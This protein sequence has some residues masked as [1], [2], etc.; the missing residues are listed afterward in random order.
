MMLVKPSPMLPEWALPRVCH[1]LEHAPSLLAALYGTRYGFLRHVMCLNAS[2]DGDPDWPALAR[3]IGEDDTDPQVSGRVAMRL[4]SMPLKTLIED[5]GPL[6]RI[7]PLIASILRKTTEYL[8]A[9]TYRELAALEGLPG[10][11]PRIRALMK[12]PPLT[13]RR[14]EIF[15]EVDVAFAHPAII[16]RL[17]EFDTARFNRM[18][19]EMRQTCAAS[20]EEAL[21]QALC[22]RTQ[23]NP[24]VEAILRDVVATHYRIPAPT[25][26]P[27][28]DIKVLGDVGSLKA[29]GQDLKNCLGALISRKI[30]AGSR[31]SVV[32]CA[33][34]QM[35]ALLR[36][37]RSGARRAWLVHEIGAQ[38]NRPIDL[39]EQHK[40]ISYLNTQLE[41]PVF[42]ASG[43]Q[44][45][46]RALSR[47]LQQTDLQELFNA[48]IEDF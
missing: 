42:A 15:L 46:G 3:A 38:A 6:L 29:A 45:N 47:E 31:I 21:A 8:S 27:G 23:C 4:F 7:T 18:V 28:S 16:A 19:A 34:T 39:H 10:S 24:K 44:R 13:G 5:A 12:S 26:R 36:P 35:V 1:F 33:R 43:D 48:R 17:E 11:A 9:P 30:L 41:E 14:L 32:L 25:V 40:F 22:A 2:F 37:I 20:A